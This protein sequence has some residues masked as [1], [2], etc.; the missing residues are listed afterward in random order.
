[1]QLSAR[2]RELFVG[3][4]AGDIF[5][6]YYVLRVNDFDSVVKTPLDEWIQFLKTGRIGDDATA[7]GLPEA[8]EKLRVDSLSLIDRQAYVRDMEAQQYQHSVIWTSWYEG[9]MKGLEESRARGQKETDWENARKM[10]AKGYPIEDIVEM[11]GLTK[12]EV[13]L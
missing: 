5:P 9:R 12:D 3:K 13:D 4:D 8:C 6:E 11:T 10:K 7:K 2:Q 1:M